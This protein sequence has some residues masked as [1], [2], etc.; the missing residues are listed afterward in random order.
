MRQKKSPSSDCAI[1]G[2]RHQ[3]TTLFSQA[4]NWQRAFVLVSMALVLSG[5][6]SQ[7]FKDYGV[8]PL[9]K[10]GQPISGISVV[11]TLR[12]AVTK[13]DANGKAELVKDE[14]FN[15][16]TDT[17][18]ACK[19]GRNRAMAALRMASDEL[20]QDHIRA[21]YGNETAANFGMGTAAT[22]ASGWSTVSGA[23]PTKTTLSA[24][25]TFFN[26]ERALV[27]EVYFKD[28]VVTAI[29]AKIRQARTEKAAQ[30]DTHYR[31]SLTDYPLMQALS[32]MVSYHYTCSLV[33]GLEKALEEG[34]TSSVEIKRSKLEQ[35]RLQLQ[36]ILDIHKANRNIDNTGDDD[37]KVRR[38]AIDNELQRLSTGAVSSKGNDKSEG[39][40]DPAGGEL[41]TKNKGGKETSPPSKPKS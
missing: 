25:S 4:G 30:L 15:E 18:G 21:I 40:A 17:G 23:L 16:A 2:S 14:C 26:A 13:P 36:N 10:E 12:N 37:L 31:D 41:D 5:C 27:N 39:T 22:L 34:Q 38:K 11:N 24:I 19:A 32:D 8:E 3:K 7:V 28:K 33:Y 35:E 6:K 20:C 29:T 9:V 1:S